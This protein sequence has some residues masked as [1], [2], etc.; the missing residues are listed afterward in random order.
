MLG[1]QTEDEE[2]GT[3][4]VDI[5]VYIDAP[6]DSRVNEIVDILEQKLLEVPGIHRFDVE[7]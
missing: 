3:Y 4:R 6:T 1:E 2:R 7:E 5:T